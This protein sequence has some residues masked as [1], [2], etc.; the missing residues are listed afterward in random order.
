ME[1][2]TDRHCSETAR[3]R[4][5]DLREK[6]ELLS[7]EIVPITLGVKKKGEKKTTFDKRGKAIFRKE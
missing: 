3:E 7:G 2:R 5:E 6:G 4:N 1:G